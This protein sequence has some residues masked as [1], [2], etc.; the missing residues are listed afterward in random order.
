MKTF[1]DYLTESKKTY[2]FLVKVA[3]DLDEEFEPH[4]K[5]AMEKFSVAKFSKGKTAP[6]QETLCDFPQL[7][8]EKVTT[9]E[10]EVYYPT[11]P[12]V[13]E[14][15]IADCCGCS[16]GHV[17]V[18]GVNEAAVSHQEEEN[19]KESE[20]KPLIGQCDPPP[21]DHQDLVGEKWK[22]S[23]LQ[24]LMKEKHGGEQYKGVNDSILA[25]NLPSEKSKEM[26]EGNSISPIGSKGK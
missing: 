9:Y 26:A 17:L 13:L 23:M 1:K 10:I 14:A 16:R 24:D 7:K 12:Q 18:R 8:N 4:L 3:G 15:Y 21:S 25:N 19:R 5:T 6:I 11:T 2:A 20:N 22:M